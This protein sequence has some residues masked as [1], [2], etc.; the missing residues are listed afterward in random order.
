MRLGSD[1]AR[2]LRD[3]RI[4]DRL[5]KLYSLEAKYL[6]DNAQSDPI[7]I[8]HGR[9]TL[10]MSLFTPVFD[11]YTKKR[12]SSKGAKGGKGGGGGSVEDYYGGFAGGFCVGPIEKLHAVYDSDIDIAQLVEPIDLTEKELPYELAISDYGVL[13][14]YRGTGDQ[15]IDER[16][17]NGKNIIV[18]PENKTTSTILADEG[19]QPAYFHLCYVVTDD[20]KLG[21]SNSTPNLRFEISN[22]PYCFLEDAEGEGISL[23]GFEV[24]DGDG[25]I[26]PPLIIYEYLRNT[27]WGSVGLEIEEIDLQSFYDAAARCAEEG[28]AITALQDS[29]E[30]TVRDAITQILQYCDGILYLNNEGKVAIRLIR[31]DSETEYPEI[32]ESLLVDEPKLTWS[33]VDD[34]WGRTEIV[35]N[36][37]ID[38]YESTAEVF[39][40]PRYSDTNIK[41]VATERFS[42]PFCKKRYLA[43]MLAR[44]L[45]N[46]GATPSCELEL[47]ALPEDGFEIGDLVSLSYDKF[48]IDNL[49]LRVTK[50]QEASTESLAQELTA[51]LEPTSDW[52]IDIENEVTGFSKGEK[53]LT[54]KKYGFLKPRVLKLGERDL[55]LFV[56]KAYGSPIMGYMPRGSGQNY[57]THE[58]INWSAPVVSGI[59]QVETKITAFGLSDDKKNLILKFDIEGKEKVEDFL[60]LLNYSGSRRVYVTACAFESNNVGTIDTNASRTLKPMTF[61]LD[62]PIT[63]HSIPEPVEGV[64]SFEFKVLVAQRFTNCA[65]PSNANQVFCFPSEVAYIHNL[66]DPGNIREVH[67][68]S[69][70][71]KSFFDKVDFRVYSVAWFGGSEFET[72]PLSFF[73]NYVVHGGNRDTYPTHFHNT[74]SDCADGD[75]VNLPQSPWGSPVTI[76]GAIFRVSSESITI[77]SGGEPP[78]EPLVWINPITGEHKIEGEFGWEVVGEVDV[79]EPMIPPHRIPFGKGHDEVAR[80]DHDH[81]ERYQLI[82]S[83]SSSEQYYLRKTASDSITHNEGSNGIIHCHIESEDS[84]AIELS[85]PDEAST[86]DTIQIIVTKAAAVSKNT[87]KIEL[88]D[89]YFTAPEVEQFETFDVTTGSATTLLC[90]LASGGKRWAVLRKPIT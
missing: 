59:Y 15:P 26:Y 1:S 53:P 85:D 71:T 42:L 67:T 66:Q 46:A 90:A 17:T 87:V 13:R 84:F 4:Q 33:C 76:E 56:G 52:R 6:T 72:C 88:A 55:A 11:I 62:V 64:Y 25:D 63:D 73:Q 43:A 82:G 40:S 51:V 7:K 65:L 79:L 70:N 32:D 86:G 28:I 78:E 58:I 2:G 16:F 30:T 75:P 38:S 35:F 20:F 48:G 36:S 81:D 49:L 68:Q 12:E 69:C 60:D 5:T 80:G 8:L 22:K 14:I 77:P 21:S 24:G 41:E 10:S 31:L 27:Q 89:G 44:R 47:R 61:Q 50:V 19:I 23:V 3:G 54:R 83:G 34:T 37:R 9:D 74:T 29:S 18:D 39:E 57:Q 45:G